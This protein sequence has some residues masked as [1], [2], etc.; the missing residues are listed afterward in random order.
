MKIF[1]EAYLDK[2]KQF[3]DYGTKEVSGNQCFDTSTT[4][5]GYYN[6]FLKDP[7]YMKRQYNLKADIVQ[8]TPEEY[9]EGCAKI[10]NSTKDSQIKQTEA[11]SRSI[12][13]LFQ[14][15]KRFN[16]RFPLTYLNYTN[17]GQEGRHRMYVAGELF[18]WDTKHPVMVVT[19][20]DEELAKEMLD[21]KHKEKVRKVLTTAISIAL[22]YKYKNIEELHNQLQWEIDG[23]TEYE[24]D[25]NSEFIFKE[26]DKGVSIMLDN[27]EETIDFEDI[28]W[29]TEDEDS[30][31]FEIDDDILLDDE[32]FETWLKDNN[33]S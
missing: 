15:I 19:Y 30:D 10:F 22:Q 3:Y 7:E 21:K 17:N 23:I 18:G 9:F 26:S 11:D 29:I 1:K 2:E 4:G 32:D 8:M 31:E 28:Q 25:I 27:V 14:V 12:Q 33:L 6:D 24:D 20:A 5:F 16:K 13:Q